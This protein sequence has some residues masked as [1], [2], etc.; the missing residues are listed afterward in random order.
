MD[1]TIHYRKHETIFPNCGQ[2]GIKSD[3]NNKEIR[4]SAAAS[5]LI[6]DFALFAGQCR[7]SGHHI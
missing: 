7:L 1:A 5:I 3:F 6:L 4:K 2:P